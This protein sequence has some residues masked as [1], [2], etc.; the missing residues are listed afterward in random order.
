[1]IEQIFVPVVAE[2][3]RV[4]LCVGAVA[5]FAGAVAIYSC[6]F[7]CSIAGGKVVLL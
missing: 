7:E 2:A 6:R 1:V 4:L 3:E 5:I